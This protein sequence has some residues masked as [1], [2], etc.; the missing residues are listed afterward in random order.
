[1]RSGQLRA[2]KRHKHKHEHEGTML[3]VPEE[4]TDVYGSEKSGNL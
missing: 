3:R 1:L 4:D 2:V